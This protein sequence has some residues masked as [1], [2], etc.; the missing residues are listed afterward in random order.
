VN[1]RYLEEQT[2]DRELERDEFH[3]NMEDMQVQ[4]EDLRRDKE[5]LDDIISNQKL[6]MDDYDIRLKEAT[7]NEQELLGRSEQ[8]KDELKSTIDKVRLLL[9]RNNAAF[10]TR[11]IIYIIL[12][13]RVS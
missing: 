11:I 9:L 10:C 8:D 2:A 13:L 7:E 4:L 12:A 1:R 6:E 5:R 3:R